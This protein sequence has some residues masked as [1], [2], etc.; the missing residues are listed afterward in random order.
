M[1]SQANHGPIVFAPIEAFLLREDA[2]QRVREREGEGDLVL[3]G[4]QLF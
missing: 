2:R 3:P 4:R 1:S